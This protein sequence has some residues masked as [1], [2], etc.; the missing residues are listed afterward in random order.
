MS[1]QKYAALLKTVEL[2]SFSLAAEQMGYT[3]PAISRMIADLEKQWNVEL[4]HRSRTGL[5]PSSFCMQLLPTLRAIQADLIA[6]NPRYNVIC[7]CFDLE[8]YRD[9]AIAI[10]KDVRISG[11]TK[12]FVEH[13]ISVVGDNAELLSQ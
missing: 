1:L 8:Q 11:A 7:K 10:A 3:Q 4:L 6:S 12:L 2:G 9:I 13:V 5:E